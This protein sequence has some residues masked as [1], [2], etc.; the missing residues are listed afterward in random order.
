VKS[1]E[2]LMRSG[3]AEGVFPGGVLLVSVKNEIVSH[4]AVG[5]ADLFSRRKATTETVFDLASLTKPLA[6]AVAILNLHQDGVLS[7]D[8]PV[9]EW[10]P[11]FQGQEKNRITLY[12]LLTHE[13]GLPAYRPYYLEMS[14]LAFS[15]RKTH[16]RSR[17]TAET[18]EHPPGIQALYSDLG[19]MLLEWVVEAASGTS[20]DAYLQTGLYATVYPSGEKGLF[21]PGRAASLE[22]ES[23]AATEC[24]PWR[25]R[26]LIGQVHDA[27]AYALGGVAGHAG[28]FGSAL[29]VWHMLW[30]LMAGFHGHATAAGL[31]QETLE[32]AF[33]PS[34]VG[35]RTLGFDTP[36]PEGSACGRH[37]SKMTV[38]HLG[39]TGTSF[40][41]DLKRQVIVIL[42][43]NRIHPHRGNETIRT[44][45]PRLHDAVMEAL[46]LTHDF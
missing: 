38:G 30:R 41:M 5:H 13:S 43:T 21:F 32:A 27:N 40:W 36:S 44:F 31:Q 9:R 28:L 46:G 23:F 20:L 17:L 6:T 2:T 39:F 26:L 29:N 4:K 34:P 19:F 45:R 1:V 15:M 37:F 11:A 10:L 42:L 7:L 25:N 33:Q 18:L 12:H 16:L 14:R 35:G 8:Q 24:C 3:V 22:Q